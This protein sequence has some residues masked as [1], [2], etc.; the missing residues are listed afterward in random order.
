MNFYI[1]V[2]ISA[3]SISATGAY[4]SILGL[5]TMFPGASIAVITMGSVLEIGKIVA[6][7][8]LHRNWRT[9]NKLIK[10]YLTAAVV[11]LILITSMGIFGFLSKAHIEHSYLTEKEMAAVEQI[12]EKV[13]REKHF[14]TRQESYIVE[15]EKRLTSSK[16]INLIDIQREEKRIEQLNSQLNKD[17]QF[18]Q[19]RIDQLAERRR[20][21]DTAAATLEAESGGLFSNKKQKLQALKELQ[22]EERASIQ[23]SIQAGESKINVHRQKADTETKESRTK[24]AEFQ[25]ARG[26]GHSEAKE[27]IEKY[28]TLIN[29]TTDRINELEVSKIIF[30]EKVRTLEAEVGPVKYIAK[31][32]EDLGG[33]EIKFDK[34]VRLVIIVLIFVFDPLAILLILAAVQ[35][36]NTG[37]S[38]GA[39][40]QEASDAG[41]NNIKKKVIHLEE[42]L[43]EVADSRDVEEALDRIQALKSQLPDEEE[44]KDIIN[45]YK[46]QEDKKKITNDK[47]GLIFYKAARTEFKKIQKI[48]RHN[49]R[50]INLVRKKTEENKSDNNSNFK[51]LVGRITK[52]VQKF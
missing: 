41:V 44:I 19:D 30:D 11:I 10:G 25:Q 28:N 1:L 18:E 26:G 24:I 33:S 14:I 4:F 50:Q 42:Q 21:L 38:V 5:A 39:I 52:K 20:E 7:V 40:P 13:L 22:E 34:A 51:K 27:E 9:A 15:E 47:H 16:D 2:L 43:K 23:S 29:E 8:W 45:F 17:V 46:K 31:L 36:L 12:E 37:K 48:A 49:R 6:A 35:G 3:L 32:F